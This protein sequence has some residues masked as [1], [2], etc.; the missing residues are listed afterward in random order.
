VLC[1]LTLTQRFTTHVSTSSHHFNTSTNE[2]S[3]DD[4]EWCDPW[5]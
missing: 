4:D 1:Y 3:C 5:I 2:Y